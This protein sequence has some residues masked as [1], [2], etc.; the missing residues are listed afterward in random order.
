MFN[1]PKREE[2]PTALDTAIETAL[3]K[4]NDLNPGTKEYIVQIDQIAKLIAFKEKTT[5]KRISPDT[6]AIIGGNLAGIL[7]IVSY[8]RVHI[9][10]SKA[11][12]FIIKP[13]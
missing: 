13:R 1:L 11:L 4:L 2:N 6:L 10:T 3:E 5:P 7:I 8:E 9:V 12:G